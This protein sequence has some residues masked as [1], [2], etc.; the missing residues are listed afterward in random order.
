MKLL[1][2]G[3]SLTDMHRNFD[4]SVDNFTSYGSG[5]VFDIAAQLMYEKPGFYK[6]LNRGISGNKVT[7]LYDRYLTDVVNEKPDILTIL[8]GV[9]DVWHEIYH[10]NGTPINVFESKYLEIIKDIKNKLPNT[11]IILMEPFFTHGEATNERFSEFEKVLDYAKIV[12]QIA[13]KTNSIFIPLQQDFDEKVNNGEN[14]QI[15]YDGVHTNP[16]G[17]HLIALKWLETFKSEV[18]E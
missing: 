9:N 13:E 5:Y 4:T 14:P 6:V 7:D 1:F 8:I 18:L 3:D 16:G 12:K 15:L 10:H 11:K 2:F 17:A